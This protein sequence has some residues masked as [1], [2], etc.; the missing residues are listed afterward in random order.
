MLVNLM[1]W[2]RESSGREAQNERRE[3]DQQIRLTIFND[4]RVSSLLLHVV[5][6]FLLFSAR[7]RFAVVVSLSLVP[8]PRFTT[9]SR[10]SLFTLYIQIHTAWSA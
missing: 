2:R 6:V 9:E 3:K 5:V 10:S 1:L 8:L 7:N 4:L